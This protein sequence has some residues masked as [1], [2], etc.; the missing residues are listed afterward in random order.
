MPAD[1]QRE[2]DWQ[3]RFVPEIKRILGEQL[4]TEGPPEEDLRHN[5]DFIVLGLDAVRV[6]CRV[7]RHSYLARYGGEFTIR[8]SRPSGT[9]TELHKVLRGW[10]DYIFY[11][12]ASTGETYLAAWLLGDLCEFRLWH[13]RALSLLAPGRMPG[14]VIRNHDSTG[15]AYRISDLPSR[16]VIGRYL[17]SADEGREP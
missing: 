14:T 13:A 5:T 17:P 7:R 15:R 10:G 6:A 1:R 2:Y 11:A 9:E 8:A 16:F 3:R 4:I 12:F